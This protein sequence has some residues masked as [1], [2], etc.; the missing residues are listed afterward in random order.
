MNFFLRVAAAK[1]RIPTKKSQR[2][3]RLEDLLKVQGIE[4]DM[5]EVEGVVDGLMVRSSGKAGLAAHG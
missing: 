2:Q 5:I 4:A 3:K 1:P